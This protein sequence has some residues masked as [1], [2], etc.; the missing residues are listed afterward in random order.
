[1]ANK[2]KDFWDSSDK[3]ELFTDAAGSLGFGA[4]LGKEWCYGKWP[5]NWLHQN[6]AL[7]D[8]IQLFLVYIYGAIT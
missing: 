6:I 3:L 1:M 5:G 8:F 2:L 7:L 4:V